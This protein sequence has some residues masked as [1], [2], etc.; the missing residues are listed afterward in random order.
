MG[1]LRTT[2]ALT[3]WTMLGATASFL[4]WTRKSRIVDVPASDYIFSNTLFARFNPNNSPVTQDL[5]VRRVPL[6]K[7]RPEL[8]EKEGRLVE[9]FSAGL[10]SGLGKLRRCT[11]AP[12]TSLLT[13]ST[14]RLCL[15]TKIP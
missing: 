15:P 8:L 5:C 4:L 10:W 14:I 11:F 6:T 13:A 7:I 1:I 3:G 2:C 9:A 12:W